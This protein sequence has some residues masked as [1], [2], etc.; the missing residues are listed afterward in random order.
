[1]AGHPPVPKDSQGRPIWFEPLIDY[2][3]NPFDKRNWDTMCADMGAAPSTVYKFRA[4]NRDLVN[5]EVEI[6]RKKFVSEMRS[7]AYKSL[8]KKL[9]K[10][11][12]ALKLF[13]QLAGDLV[14]RTE[15]KVDMLTPEEKQAKARALIEELSQKLEP[16]ESGST[17]DT[18]TKEPGP[19][20]AQ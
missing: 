3:S 19:E 9:E 2:L 13:F 20:Q 8:T 6:R 7:A 14:E 15:S 16:K 1:M 17:S 4:D 12:N 5:R 11:T 18:E 10:D